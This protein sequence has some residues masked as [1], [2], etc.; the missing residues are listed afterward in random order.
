MSSLK[1][2][3]DTECETGEGPLWHPEDEH[4]YWCDIPRGRVYRYDPAID[5]YEC[6]YRDDHEQ[7]GGFTIQRDGSLLLFQEAGAVRQLFRD[8]WT[9]ETVL[10]PDP[11]RF[12]ERFNDVIADPEGRVFAGVMPDTERGIPGQLYRLDTDGTFSLVRES[13][14]LPNG[15]GFTPDLSQLYFT[16]TC[17]VDPSK[18]G[19]IY[20]YDYDRKNGSLTDPEVF[21]D[22]SNIDG[23]PDGMTVDSEGYVWSAF[24]D[25]S[26]IYR[27]APD[28]TRERT[29]L[30]DPRKVSSLT[31]AG[32]DFHTAY[33]TTACV[34]TR[35]IEGPGA[36]SVYRVD[37][38]VAGRPEF[39]SAIDPDCR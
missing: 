27:F 23:Y 15:M 34:E 39:R 13:C 19:Y 26:A 11:D 25:G 37:T 31:F 32:D 8:D 35:E 5:D 21:V 20:Q 24:W 38:G 33:V 28:G 14:V 10:T 3:V 9:T 12:H 4:L 1:Q 16:D 18:P 30:F 6:V 36:G 7:I 2:V 17:E 22:A 29:I